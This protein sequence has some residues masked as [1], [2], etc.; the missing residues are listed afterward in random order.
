MMSRSFAVI[1]SSF[2]V[3]S[4][5]TLASGATVGCSPSAPQLAGAAGSGDP[6][7]D[8]SQQD[9]GGPGTTPTGGLA[10]WSEI[11]VDPLF[12]VGDVTGDARGVWASLYQRSTSGPQWTVKVVAVAP[13]GTL[14]ERYSNTVDSVVSSNYGVA[15]FAPV[16]S[17][18][19]A[20]GGE[21]FF[22]IVGGAAPL[23]LGGSGSYI[24]ALY[25]RA[26]NDVWAG[27]RVGT[28]THYTGGSSTSASST[29]LLTDRPS[30]QGLW[31]SGS[32]LYLATSTGLR[33]VTLPLTS[34][35]SQLA[36]RV[37]LGDFA[38]VAGSAD[39]EG[40]AVGASG[41]IVHFDGTAWKAQASGTT[42]D[43]RSV[44]VRSKSDVWASGAGALL[45]HDGAAWSAVNEAGMPRGASSVALAGDGTLW[46]ASE[47]KLLRR[48]PGAVSGTPTAPLVAG[49]DGGACA[50]G[51]PNDTPDVA[52][53]ITTPY[54]VTACAPSNDYDNYTFFPPAGKSGFVSIT[55]TDTAGAHPYVGVDTGPSYASSAGVAADGAAGSSRSVFVPV[56]AGQRRFIDVAQSASGVAVGAYSLSVKYTIFDD[57]YE[58]NDRDDA[59]S[60]ITSGTTIQSYFPTLVSLSSS[61]GEPGFFDAA[62]FYEAARPAGAFS[63]SLGNVPAG[64]VGVMT[65]EGV[66]NGTVN[67]TLL[68]NVTGA[69]G[70]PIT[71]HGTLAVAGKVRVKIQDSA[72]RV[73]DGATAPPAFTQKYSLLI[74]N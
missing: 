71:F 74:G 70:A 32:F 28:L 15:G 54:A 22:D 66:P 30:V 37:A 1:G 58:P 63:V 21:W 14:T 4:A 23:E 47:G 59:A 18:T 29:Y 11:P 13:D 8:P 19:V 46:L 45:H 61:F 7:Q 69:P 35:D 60:Q 51:E 72:T 57:K 10:A 6:S 25:G 67:G 49:P 53:E 52:T 27:S 2:L 38:A 20:I 36:T 24:Q 41:A 3:V 64:S 5:A 56:P 40:F 73:L 12:Q 50:V 55:L 43:L 39:D 9:D 65:I 33:S 42:T 16:T 31:Q 62:D 34:A 26:A 17:T 68:G 48:S 44:A